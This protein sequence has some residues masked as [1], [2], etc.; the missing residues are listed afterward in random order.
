MY[1]IENTSQEVGVRT[2]MELIVKCVIIKMGD[3]S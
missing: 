1:F 3:N 2:N